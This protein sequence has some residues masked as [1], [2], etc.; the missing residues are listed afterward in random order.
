MV[1]GKL[2]PNTNEINK[3]VGQALEV[4]RDVGIEEN[5]DAG[6][7][8]IYFEVDWAHKLNRHLILNSYGSNEVVFNE[9]KFLD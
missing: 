7:Y 9:M 3:F 5:F 2:D 6:D 8:I 1:V 4:D